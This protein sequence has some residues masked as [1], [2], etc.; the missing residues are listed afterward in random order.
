MAFDLNKALAFLREQEKDEAQANHSDAVR[1]AIRILV[2]AKAQ[3]HQ[4]AM[5]K[6]AKLDRMIRLLDEQIPKAQADTSKETNGKIRRALAR[7]KKRRP[8][9]FHPEVKVNFPGWVK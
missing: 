4:E 7:E 1:A 6:E 5:A 9:A 2:R 3:I 8:E